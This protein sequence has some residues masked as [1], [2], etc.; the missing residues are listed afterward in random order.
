VIA[1]PRRYD[2]PGVP[3]VWYR[4]REVRSTI[5]HKT[6]I[7][8]TFDDA[9]LDRLRSLFLD[10]AW[11]PTREP[12]HDPAE[13]ANPF[14][15]FDQIPAVSRYPN[16]FFEVEAGGIGGFVDELLA[17]GSGADL[18]RLAARHGIRRTSARFRETVDWLHADLRR[19]DPG[20]AGVYDLARYVNL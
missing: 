15:A 6:H 14:V 2:D 5:V 18:E 3:C 12:G 7:V 16:S 8:Y 20:Q 9:R 19:R 1:T 4:L 13:A 10:T 11:E 17:V